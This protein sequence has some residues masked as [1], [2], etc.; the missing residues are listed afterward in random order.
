MRKKI[1]K[2]VELGKGFVLKHSNLVAMA[3]FA[4][5]VMDCNSTCC[6]L[7]GQPE[8]PKGSEEF[9]KYA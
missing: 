1:E 4:V 9:R 8:L 3:A 5:V 6:Y 2:V 7:L